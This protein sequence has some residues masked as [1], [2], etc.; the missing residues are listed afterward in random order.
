MTAN[1]LRVGNIEYG[2]G[3]HVEILGRGSFGVVFCG[4]Y[5][6]SDVAVKRIQLLDATEDREHAA[7]LHF[8]HPNVLKLYAEETD[9]N[10]R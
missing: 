7:L 1:H 6:N 9:A 5:R 3:Y 4:K 2:I 10:F 8:D